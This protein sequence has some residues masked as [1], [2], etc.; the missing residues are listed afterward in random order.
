MGRKNAKGVEPKST[1]WPGR[2]TRV[3]GAALILISSLALA[4][5]LTA[6]KWSL[7]FLSLFPL[8]VGLI[9]LYTTIRTPSLRTRPAAYATGILAIA[10]ALLLYLSSSLVVSG[11]ITLLLGFLILDGV[12][13]LGQALLRPLPIDP[14]W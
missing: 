3:V 11:V 10:A 4:A 14:V 1:R 2:W 12:L 5:P 6:G 13:K 7:Q 8:A 9:G